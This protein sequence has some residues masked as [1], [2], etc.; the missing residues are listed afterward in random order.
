MRSASSSAA[1]GVGLVGRIDHAS[2]APS[3]RA[4]RTRQ[5]TVR[6]DPA[7]ARPDLRFPPPASAKRSL[8]PTWRCAEMP[9]RRTPRQRRV[10]EAL[11]AQR[12]RAAA[13]VAQGE[14]TV[15]SPRD[16]GNGG[17]RACA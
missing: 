16:A 13:G 8:L 7:R 3:R 1:I 11:V 12:R 2:S 14:A 10:A 15:H 9:R 4:S 17:V 6:G 5:G